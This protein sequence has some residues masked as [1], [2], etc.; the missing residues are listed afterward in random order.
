[1][2][3]KEKALKTLWLCSLVETAG[4]RYHKTMRYGDFPFSAI[5]GQLLMKSALILN[6]VDPSIGGVLIRG[7]K[8]TGK[9]TAVRSLRGLLPPIR[10]VRGCAYHCPP[11]DVSR[12]HEGCRRRAEAGE[13]LESLEIPTPLV[14]LPLNATEDRLVGTLNIEE[15]LSS[16][17][18]RFEPGLLAAANRGILYIDEVNLLEDHLVDML[19]DAA[20]TGVNLVEREGLSF[21]HPASF[22][23]AGTMNPEEGELRPQ[24]LDRF[25]LC[26]TV[27]GVAEEE[28]RLEILK[29]RLAFE[30][31]PQE[32]S[33]RWA[34]QDGVLARQII[35]ARE[36]LGSVR[37]DEAM[38]RLIVK[39]A[40]EAGTAGH[41]AEID[42]MKAAAALA[43]FTE[44]P[45]VLGFH[46]KEAARLV[47][48]H[49]MALGILEGPEGALE[50]IENLF[51][52]G[53]SS[54]E[55]GFSSR[56]FDERPADEGGVPEGYSEEF[57]IDPEILGE[58]QVP[59]NAAAGSIIFTYLKKKLPSGNPGLKK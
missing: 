44:S 47:L 30:R 14:D 18:Q 39:T 36:R 32:F 55:T 13:V 31:D 41:R 58:M 42:M 20:A 4:I 28:E 29:R 24:F 22:I 5:V 2:I 48:P 25:G 50:K 21:S 9:T 38:L 52:G 12:M 8:G 26:V 3:G 16:G 15:A 46:V 53:N 19:L 49:R 57:G 34:G 6:A 11:D 43:A 56:D 45:R 10:V 37:L 1:M 23:L 27:C 7:Q 33:G 59:G 40:S 17:R 51:G 54:P 35:Q